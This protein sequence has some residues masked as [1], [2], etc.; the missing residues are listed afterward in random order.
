MS[1]LKKVLPWILRTHCC[2]FLDRKLDSEACVCADDSHTETDSQLQVSVALSGGVG[3]IRAWLE[4][5]FLLR[6]GEQQHL[7]EQLVPR[8][9]P[10]SRGWHERRPC[11]TCVRSL[12]D[13]RDVM[14]GRGDRWGRCAGFGL[15]VSILI[16]TSLVW[17]AG[18][19][20]GQRIIC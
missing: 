9:A 1:A 13:M 3:I 11:G 16:I 4:R 8:A 2:L 19:Q 20:L 12:G 14:G 10:S 18:P 7:Y 17:T 6:N 5:A 15:A